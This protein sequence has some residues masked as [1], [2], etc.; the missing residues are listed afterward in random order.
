MLLDGVVGGCVAV[1]PVGDVYI[2]MNRDGFVRCAFGI[3]DSPQIYIPKDTSP[4][5]NI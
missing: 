3:V 4:R 2:S 5:D 1:M